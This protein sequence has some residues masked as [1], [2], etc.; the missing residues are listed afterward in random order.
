M[1]VW[2]AALSIVLSGCATSG[3][4]LR[5]GLPSY[6]TAQ[7]ALA[8]GAPDLALR[9][10]SGLLDKSP[11]NV[12]LMNCQGDAL[13][14]QG[15]VPEAEASFRQA[16]RFDA[17]S[18][19]AQIGLGRL[20]LVDRPA[21]AEALFLQVLDR[22]PRNAV[23]LNNL[24]IARDLQGR[25][26]AA[27][28]AYGQAIAAA[29]DMRAAKINLALSLA[30]SGRGTE[31][32]RLVRPIADAPGSTIK[33]RHVLAAVLGMSGERAEAVRLLQPDLATRQ[34]DEALEGYKALPTPR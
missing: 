13:T 34:V 8:N 9:I 24:G 20:S 16:L 17:S 31:A 11:R 14:A 28:D 32:V 30:L 23:A 12:D 3:P 6:A 21:E 10:C 1:R 26:P 15:R 18:E 25:H 5:E 29:P 22:R 2:M 19:G 33:E 4:I 7:T 27:Q